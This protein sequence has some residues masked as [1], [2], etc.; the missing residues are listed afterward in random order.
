MAGGGPPTPRFDMSGLV[1]AL[2]SI[3]DEDSDGITSTELVEQTGRGKWWVNKQ[4]R[5]L[6]R[7]GLLTPTTKVITAMD[8]RRLRVS[9]Y[10]LSGA[11]SKEELLEVLEWREGMG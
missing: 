8:G 7:A 9:A 10:K 3:A 4:L 5:R 2:A 11:V 6:I 1:E